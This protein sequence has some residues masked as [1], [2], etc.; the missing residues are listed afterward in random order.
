V[1]A[2]EQSNQLRRSDVV[3]ATKGRLNRAQR[4]MIE[5]LARKDRGSQ[6]PFKKAL[7][8]DDQAERCPLSVGKPDLAIAKIILVFT[9]LLMRL[10][11]LAT[12]GASERQL[13]EELW[14]ALLKV[15]QKVLGQLLARRSAQ[16][17]EAE[18]K[19]M[20]LSPD[21]VY[22][23]MDQDYNITRTTTLGEITFPLFA[24]RMKAA[25]GTST[26]YT[27][28]REQLFPYHKQCRSSALCLEWT[29][30]LGSQQT[31]R[32]AESSL[33][34][35]SH[36]AV[37]LADNTIAAHTVL[38]GSIIDRDQLYR[39]P[40]EIR[41][42]LATTATRDKRTGQPIVY[43]STD[44]HAL[45]RF[46]DETWHGAWKMANGLRIWCVD[47]KTDQIIHLGG[48]YTWGDC[49]AVEGIFK[50]LT[51]SGHLPVDGDYGDG[52]RAKYVIVTDGATWIE[53]RIVPIFPGSCAILDAY[54]ALETVSKL[55][56]E[57]YG[58]ETPESK[59]FY[60]RAVYFLLGE[61]EANERTRKNRKG[62]KKTRKI[63]SKNQVDSNIKSGDFCV[64]AEELNG[65]IPKQVQEFIDFIKEI[66]IPEKNENG[67]QR[68]IEFIDGNAH[69]IDY[70]GYRD[71]GYKIGSGAMESLHRT[72]SQ[73][74]LKIPGAKWLKETAQSI[75]NI[76][77]MTIVGKWNEFWRQPNI[78]EK[79]TAGF[80]AKCEM[81]AA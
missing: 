48:E 57:I 68:L 41:K 80:K 30:R 46:I 5:A 73:M 64:Y 79:L 23:R 60:R 55:A 14:N 62:H 12:S 42:I 25:A 54:H 18:I 58:S 59:A 4:R 29:A 39:S 9:E 43:F 47:Q 69:R 28:A 38:I 21:D 61:K 75:F 7:E 32:E 13:E 26:T 49:E 3:I 67:R 22:L 6:E 40:A 17:S 70:I 51:Q 63:Y 2:R 52:I 71:I 1:L 76:R 35:F 37:T 16:I 31:F 33:S 81:T 77:M 53:Q 50:S 24:F 8:V 56:K 20:G 74:R 34:F 15:G 11:A 65:T 36:G 78:T 19:R 44:A 10:F 66:K 72:G 27:P 45:R